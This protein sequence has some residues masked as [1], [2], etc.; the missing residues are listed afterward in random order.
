MQTVRV[1]VAYSPAV[2]VGSVVHVDEE[3]ARAL[4]DLGYVEVVGDTPAPEGNVD[5]D[6][7]DVETV[8]DGDPVP[9]AQAAA[10]RRNADRRKGR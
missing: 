10:D 4:A 8:V 3:S 7:I 2:A 6:P 1:L 9:A 5:P